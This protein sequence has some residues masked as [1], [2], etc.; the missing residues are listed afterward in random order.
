MGC[1]IIAVLTFL[2]VMG[3]FAYYGPLLVKF[4]QAGFF[5]KVK[6]TDYVGSRIDNIRRL[7]TAMMLYHESEGMFPQDT[8]WMDAIENRLQTN[9]LEK[10]EGK[11]KLHNPA[12][13]DDL[14]KYGFAM[15]KAASGKYVDDLPEKGK[16][17]L[18]YETS[19]P[20][21]NVSGDPVK[22]ASNPAFD[23]GNITISVD[24]TVYQDGKPVKDDS[25]EKP[26]K[27]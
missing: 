21:R 7:R 11:K 22:D 24:G 9:D 12:L 14:T 18:I 4:Y 5:E 8:G 17:I 27:P 26:P 23:G 10:G 16:T 20:A 15:N 13:G 2:A 25:T 3:V 1:R 6:R 19:N